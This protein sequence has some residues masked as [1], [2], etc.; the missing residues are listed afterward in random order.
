M[1]GLLLSDDD[2]ALLTEEE[3]GT[4]LDLLA[5]VADEFALSGKQVVAEE[6]SG[7]VDELLYGGSAGGGKSEWLIE[8]V[9]RL[10]LGSPG[11]Q[12]L[13]LRSSFPEL[14]RTLIRRSIVH[15]SKVPAVDRPV[16]RAADKEWRFP[17]GSVVEFGY[18]E[19]DEDV[20]QYLSAEYDCIA[21]DEATEFTEYQANMLSSRLR[22]TRRK[23]ARGIRPHMVLCSNPGG[24]GHQWV[25]ERFVDS[26]ADQDGDARCTEI[27]VRLDDGRETRRTVGSVPATAYDNPHIDPAY[28]ESLL[29]LP[30]ALRKQYLEGSWD[31]FEGMYFE[32]FKPSITLAD[33]TQQP[34]HVCRPFQIPSGWGRTC[35]MDYGYVAPMGVLWC[36]FDPDT[37]IGYV[38]R[39]EK[40]TQ[41][42]V[43]DQAKLV[44]ARSKG[45]DERGVPFDERIDAT[46]LDPS[47]W[48]KEGSGLSI[49][50]QYA[51]EG[52]ICRK[53]DNRRVDGWARVREWLAP[54][55]F[56]SPEGEVTRPG[57]VI[58]DSCPELI[59]EFL[60][61]MRDK[62]NPEDLDTTGDDHLLD[63][64]RY[65]LMAK[66]PRHRRQ[67]PKQLSRA[68]AKIDAWEKRLWSRKHRR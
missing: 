43:T 52:L 22:T 33:G 18:C 14:R 63:A 50:Q 23:R 53:A 38:Y 41:L 39:E 35:G 6:V 36:A 3:Q 4:Y 25:K 37:G 1:E 19:S 56:P 46:M 10:S 40:R 61:A 58:F 68:E 57:L 55:V 31:S 24:R 66:P 49:A 16:W 64:L 7:R 5:G 11:H 45:E 67:R 21:L 29:A 9:L 54:T 20:R 47:C 32:E 48:R 30:P 12:A 59:K 60:N 34:W 8:H 51:K 17:N 27:V 62:N 13:V 44:K 15:Y 42:T 26:T 65:L 2:F 28:I